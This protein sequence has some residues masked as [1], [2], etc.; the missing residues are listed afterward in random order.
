MSKVKVNTIYSESDYRR[1]KFLDGNRDAKA[2]N[3]ILESIDNVGYVSCP[4]LVNEH[5]EIVDGQNRFYA[6][7]E[8]GL[9]IEYYVVD[10]VG[11]QEARYMNIGRSNWTTMDYVKSY[12]AD[13]NIN[14]I[15][16]YD[17]TQKLYTKSVLS[18]CM[19]S[20]NL[21]GTSGHPANGINTGEYKVTSEKYNES[22][23]IIGLI[24]DMSEAIDGMIWESSRCVITSLAFALRCEGVDRERFVKL[25]KTQYPT[26]HPI[27]TP[28][29]FFIDLSDMYNKN[30]RK[31]NRVFFDAI[32][33]QEA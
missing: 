10:G 20:L 21:V 23:K 4:I 25:I 8:L 5:M 1:F 28:L 6:L 7:Q 33:R 12:M 13:G 27:A 11:I 24:N 26:L 9:P 19:I 3:K 30:Q 18:A 15:R 17:L 29:P 22:L 32:Y 31:A 16:L 2:V 14:Y